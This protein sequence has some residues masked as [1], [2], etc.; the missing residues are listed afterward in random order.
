MTHEEDPTFKGFLLKFSGE[1]I[2][3]IE[4]GYISGGIGVLVNSN[5]WI[6]IGLFH[7]KSHLVCKVD[8]VCSQG[9]NHRILL[10]EVGFQG[11]GSGR[12]VSNE[13][14]PEEEHGAQDYNEGEDQLK[15]ETFIISADDSQSF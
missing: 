15:D 1:D 13:G 2:K 9:D 4:I 3:L 7:D 12:K 11:D 8:I 10:G 6:G 5:G 14:D